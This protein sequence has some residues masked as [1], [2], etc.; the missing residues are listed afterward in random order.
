VVWFRSVLVD[1]V[2]FSADRCGSVLIGVVRFDADRCGLVR[3]FL[4]V[5]VIPTD[6]P[7]TPVLLSVQFARLDALANQRLAA[8]Q[9]LG[10]VGTG[11]VLGHGAV[12]FGVVRFD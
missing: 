8:T 3:A 12:R 1:A 7:L 9:Q 2:W 4:P 11:Q 10:S 5:Q 6:T